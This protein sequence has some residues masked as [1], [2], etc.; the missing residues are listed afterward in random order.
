MSNRHWGTADKI[1]DGEQVSQSVSQS[2][3]QTDRQSQVDS[4]TN[5]NKK[6]R[7]ADIRTGSRTVGQSDSQTETTAP[8]KV[9]FST[10]LLIDPL[11]FF[12]FFLPSVI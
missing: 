1:Q 2:G 7:L 6:Y 4:W 9:G 10:N 8:F 5:K 3:R 11:S 12:H